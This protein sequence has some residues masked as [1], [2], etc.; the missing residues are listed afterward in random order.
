MGIEISQGFQILMWFSGLKGVIAF[1][2]ASRAMHEFE[3]GDI[4]IT[5]TLIYSI[6]G[7]KI[8]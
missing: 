1:A 6:T 5:M 3:H 8:I 7:V 2:L 4:I